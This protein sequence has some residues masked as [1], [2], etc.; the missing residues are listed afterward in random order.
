MWR[1]RWA[2]WSPPRRPSAGLWRRPIQQAMCD[3]GKQRGNDSNDDA[4]TM[5]AQSG[6]RND[7]VAIVLTGAAAR[8]AFQAGALAELIPALSRDGITP[9]IWL[10]T[11]AG[12]V[13]AALWCS[14][15]HLGPERA[16]QEMLDIWSHMGDGNVYRPLVPFALETALQYAVGFLGQGHGT[17]S[18][19]DTQPMRRTTDDLLD[20][21]QLAENVT[22]GVAD[23]VGVVASRIPTNAEDTVGGA[24]SGGRSVLFLHEREASG[25]V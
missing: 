15:A 6:P 9:S 16:A 25:Y 17:T 3:T 19:L 7:S 21:D 24:A 10:G 18:L 20:T 23:A 2:S 14:K 4:T 11:S 13:N 1:A 8:G 5:N 12:A 22:P